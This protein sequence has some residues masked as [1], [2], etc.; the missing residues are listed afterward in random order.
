M[1]MA[2]GVLYRDGIRDA[3]TTQYYF[4]FYQTDVDIIRDEAMKKIDIVDIYKTIKEE[5]LEGI[6]KTVDRF[7]T[8]RAGQKESELISELRKILE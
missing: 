4:K 5:E 1:C 7:N 2:I 8:N 3:K 6:S